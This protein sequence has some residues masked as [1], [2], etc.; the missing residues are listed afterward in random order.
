MICG[1]GLFTSLAA[2]IAAIPIED[3]KEK[4]PNKEIKEELAAIKGTLEKMNQN[5]L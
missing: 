2:N 5:G 3:P 1:V 4:D